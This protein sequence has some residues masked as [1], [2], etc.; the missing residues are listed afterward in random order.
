MVAGISVVI[1]IWLG[2]LLPVDRLPRVGGGDK[3][4]HFAAYAACSFCWCALAASS[5]GKLAWII[6]LTTMGVVIEFLQGASGLRHFERTDML[7]NALGT[8][9]GGTL[10]LLLPVARPAAAPIPRTSPAP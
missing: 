9:A 6:G 10:T 1:L 8:I 7:A 3:L 5:R 2:S 4:H